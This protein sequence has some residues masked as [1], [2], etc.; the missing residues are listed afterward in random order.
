M[1][2]FIR[3]GRVWGIFAL[4][5]VSA[6]W[7]FGAPKPKA[8]NVQLRASFRGLT[9]P[10]LSGYDF[11]T[12]KILNDDQGPY[13]T[14]SD[15]LITVWL[16]PDYG[17]LDFHVYHHASRKVNV[18]FPFFT[19]T[20]GSLPD[21]VGLYDGLPDEPVDY[22]RFATHWGQGFGGP[23][24]NFLTMAD[25]QTAQVRIWT[26][27]CTAERHYFFL[28]YNN[29]NAGGYTA[30]LQVTAYN[31]D[32]DPEVD[33]WIIQ[34]IDG[35]NDLVYINKLEGNGPRQYYCQLG[36]HYMPFLLTLERIN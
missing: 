1:L 25:G 22:F 10:E 8:P 21:T 15:N 29:S 35:T 23:Q 20:C 3:Q 2:R 13:V 24:L 27:V 11:F 33:R 16:T 7:M 5:I 32:S 6:I 14:T 19:G 17:Q 18:V 31:T 34:P 9:N 26:Q 36:A 30:L 12:D 28:N 4:I